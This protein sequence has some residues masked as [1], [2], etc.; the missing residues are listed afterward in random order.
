MAKKTVK[1]PVCGMIVDRSK[2]KIEKLQGHEVGFCSEGCR[3]K[4]KTNPEAYGTMA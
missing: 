3:D 2:A 1:D 4:F